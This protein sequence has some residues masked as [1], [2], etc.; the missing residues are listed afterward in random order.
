MSSQ[1]M[2]AEQQQVLERAVRSWDRRWRTYETLRWLPRS[3]VPELGAGIVIAVVSRLRPW[4]L[5][6]QI[7]QATAALLAL[8]LIVM[9]GVIWL[10]PRPLLQAA[11]RYD[12]LFGLDERVSTALELLSGRIQADERIAALQLADTRR[13]VQAVRAGDAIRFRLPWR[14]WLLVLA[15]LVAFGLLVWL[16]NPQVEALAGRSAERAAIEDAAETLREAA[17]QVAT[18]PNLQD[19]ERQ[20][21]LQALD[22]SIKTLEQPDISP[23]EAFAALSDARAA[24]R[25]QADLFNQRLNASAAAMQSAAEALGE[26]SPEIQQAFQEAQDAAEALQQLM[27][28][29]AQAMGGMSEA[30]RQQLAEAMRQAASAMQNANPQAAGQ[31]QQ[32]ADALQSGQTAD[33]QSAMQQAADALQEGQQAQQAQQQTSERLDQAAQQAQQAAQNVAQAGQQQGQQTQPGQSGQ[34]G[35]QGQQGQQAQSGQSGDQAGD[36]AG[37]GQS[38]SA[39][40]GGESQQTTGSQSGGEGDSQGEAGQSEAGGLGAGD[41]E[42]GPGQ[43]AAGGPSSRQ[44]AGQRN[45][46]DGEGESAFAPVFAPRRIGGEPGSEQMALEPDSSSAPVVEG[47]FAQNPAGESVVP[48]NEVFADYANAASRA[49]ESDYIP[50]GLRDVVRDYFTSLEP[51]SPSP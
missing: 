40:T 18:D 4:L 21:L 39:Q 25:Q 50:L 48:Y 1:T 28:D 11:R 2:Y 15:L 27:N 31:M 30:Q 13:R 41:G 20:A 29:L 26:L 8:G 19:A 47:E 12:L 34:K 42:G 16:P 49:L 46:P 7:L 44:I 38:D 32:A 35:E 43:D 24:L 22:T 5:P 14:D 23:E 51:S 3:L 45:N 10:R 37:Q 9:L 17:E 6:E 33:A 36:Q